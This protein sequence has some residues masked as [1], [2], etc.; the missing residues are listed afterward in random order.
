MGLS[1]GHR[2][3]SHDCHIVLLIPCDT[4]LSPQIKGTFN[5]R[6]QGSI[7][8]PY[9]QRNCWLNLATVVCGPFPPRCVSAC[10]SVCVSVCIT[11]ESI[12]ELDIRFELNFRNS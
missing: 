8:N 12:I 5:P 1:H 3:N 6:R 7:E 2:V 11:F 9:S 10:L 4:F